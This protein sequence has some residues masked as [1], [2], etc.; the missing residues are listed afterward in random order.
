MN[1]SIATPTWRKRTAVLLAGLVPLWSCSFVNG[2]TQRIAVTST[3]PDVR[4]L[5]DGQPVGTTGPENPLIIRLKRKNSHYL[6]GVKEG[7]SSYPVNVQAT[8]SSLG[9]LDVIGGFIFLLPFITLIT[10]HAFELEPDSVYL[11]LEPR[12]GT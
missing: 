5:A 8:L 2:T 6:T 9:V 7:Y 11:N 4:V 3:V 10:G 1:H 12:A